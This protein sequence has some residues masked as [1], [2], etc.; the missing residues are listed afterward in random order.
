MPGPERVGEPPSSELYLVSVRFAQ[1]ATSRRVF[2]RAR[3]L[4]FSTPTELS[5]YRFF[6]D[7]SWHVAVLGEQPSE[8]LNRRLRMIL[9]TGEPATIPDPIL[10]FLIARRLDHIRK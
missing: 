8:D 2:V 1:E 5:T 7:R 6:L 9:A 3:A 10:A 4:I